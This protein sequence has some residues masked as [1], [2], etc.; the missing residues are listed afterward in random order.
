MLATGVGAWMLATGRATASEASAH[1]DPTAA[2]TV[3][4][5]AIDGGRGTPLAALRGVLATRVGEV[6]DPAKLTRDRDA[7]EAELAAQGYLSAVVGLPSVTR[8]SAGT[9]VVFDLE[10]GP[11]FHVRSVVVSGPGHHETDVVTI[12]AGD[13]AVQSRL[14]N[15]RDSLALMLSRRSA[16]PPT[17]ELR[18]QRDASAAALDVELLTR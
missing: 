1:V 4:G 2:S 11:L 9:Y 15:A 6:L 7:L 16:K 3:R 12:A 13:A 18:V 10:R 14:V 5:V 17:V 8:T